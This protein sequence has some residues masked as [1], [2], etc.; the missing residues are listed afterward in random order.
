M[1]RTYT[2]LFVNG[3][4]FVWPVSISCE[5]LTENPVDPLG[6]ESLQNPYNPPTNPPNPALDPPSRFCLPSQQFLL[7]SENSP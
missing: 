3:D 1:F 7:Y 6:M 2:D 5:E 4:L